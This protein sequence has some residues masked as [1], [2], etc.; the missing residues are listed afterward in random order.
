MSAS[1]NLILSYFTNDLAVR[2]EQ[3]LTT[4][5]S[6]AQVGVGS[7]AGAI[8]GTSHHGDRKRRG[9]VLKPLGDLL[10]DGNEVT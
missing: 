1:T 10:G 8:N 6:N 7:L 3:G 9:V 2:K 4:S 5:A